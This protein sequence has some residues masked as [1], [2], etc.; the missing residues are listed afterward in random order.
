MEILKNV[1]NI[2]RYAIL[3]LI[4]ASIVKAYMGLS[5]KTEYTSGDK[6]LNLFTLIFSH[7]QLLIGLV[8][9]FTSE[10]V[11]IAHQNMG[12]AMKDKALR[13]WSVEHITMMIVAIALITV[14]Y[15]TSKKAAESNAKFKKIAV[16]FTIALLLILAAIPWTGT[17]VARQPF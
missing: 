6:K 14:G 13:F 1:H 4:I 17:T 8:L 10:T 11:K 9:Y 15:S 2:L 3:L 7:I 5:K 16:F 12:A